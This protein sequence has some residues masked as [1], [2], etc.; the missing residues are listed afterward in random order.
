[1]K[2]TKFK[3]YTCKYRLGYLPGDQCVDWWTEK[4]WAEWRQYIEELKASGQYGKKEKVIVTMAD[5][6]FWDKP[7]HPI[8]SKPMESYRMELINFKSKNKNNEL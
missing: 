6:P 8:R 2:Q 1:M 4:D 3:E 7:I 5:H